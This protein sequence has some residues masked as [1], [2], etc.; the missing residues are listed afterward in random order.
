MFKLIRRFRSVAGGIAIYWICQCWPISALLI[1]ATLY[2]LN[3]ESHGR[4]V[5]SS[6]VKAKVIVVENLTFDFGPDAS[7][8]TVVS[9]DPASHIGFRFQDPKTEKYITMNILRNGTPLLMLGA[10]RSKTSLAPW[11]LRVGRSAHCM[12]PTMASK[13]H[14]YHL[15]FTV[16]QVW[17]FMEATRSR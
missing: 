12:L 3:Y 10:R 14:G 11:S 1:L 2:S 15:T 16:G 8:T 5:G 4:Q 6:R 7:R 13:I 17:H 9:A